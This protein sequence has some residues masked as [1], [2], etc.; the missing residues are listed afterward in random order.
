ML[1]SFDPLLVLQLLVF[2]GILNMLLSKAPRKIFKL[3]PGIW[4]IKKTLISHFHF[5][6]SKKYGLTCFSLP[7][8][9]S[10]LPFISGIGSV[11]PIHTAASLIA[12]VQGIRYCAFWCQVQ[13]Q[14][15]IYEPVYKKKS[16]CLKE[17]HSIVNKEL[18]PAPEPSEETWPYN[19][20]FKF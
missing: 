16:R 7:T 11:L 1:V 12:L 4:R 2:A 8:P 20:L 13:S 3:L 19:A 14:V 6:S 17:R 9:C 5:H 15:P 10:S 18:T